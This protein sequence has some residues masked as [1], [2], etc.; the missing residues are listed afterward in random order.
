MNL[1]HIQLM[2]WDMQFQAIA[3]ISVCL[4]D[5]K[6]IRFK[7]ILCRLHQGGIGKINYITSLLD[8]GPNLSRTTLYL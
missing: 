5:Q 3:P 4:S 8:P 2:F 6:A 1:V 7:L